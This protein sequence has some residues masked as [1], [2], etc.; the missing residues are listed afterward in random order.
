MF[1]LIVDGL[2]AIEGIRESEDQ[3]L[4]ITAGGLVLIPRFV[5]LRLMKERQIAKTIS[6]GEE[7]REL[8]HR[9]ARLVVLD[10]RPRVKIAELIAGVEIG[11]RFL[12]TVQQ[13]FELSPPA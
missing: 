3:R 11:T 8:V 5:D 2:I 9:V 4:T 7:G 10:Q 6:I 12:E 1:G 13:L